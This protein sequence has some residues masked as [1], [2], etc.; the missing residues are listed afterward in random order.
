MLGSFQPNLVGE[1]NYT[2]CHW[3]VETKALTSGRLSLFVTWGADICVQTLYAETFDETSDAEP[4][5]PSAFS[6]NEDIFTKSICSV[7]FSLQET[8][9]INDTVRKTSY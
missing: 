2:R 3:K 4:C 7:F 9:P 1:L 6:S 5:N 8:K